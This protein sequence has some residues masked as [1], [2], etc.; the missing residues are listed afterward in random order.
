[1]EAGSS[2]SYS[3]HAASSRNSGSFSLNIAMTLGGACFRS[4][5]PSA[6]KARFRTSGLASDSAAESASADDRSPTL[7]SAHAAVARTW[8]LASV[9]S[10]CLLYTSD[11]ADDLRCVD[12]RGR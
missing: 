8:V 7:P 5:L 2:I 4:E 9:R 12:L 6:H 11:A 1:M 10:A 3:T